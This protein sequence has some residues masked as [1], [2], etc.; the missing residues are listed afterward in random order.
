MVRNAFEMMGQKERDNSVGRRH[1]AQLR[2]MSGAEDGITDALFRFT[3]P[4]STA[5]FWCPPM[6]KGKI[7]L[8]VFP[9]RRPILDST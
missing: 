4:I 6:Y 7:D 9:G 8:R 2:R 1:E 3:K 5:Y